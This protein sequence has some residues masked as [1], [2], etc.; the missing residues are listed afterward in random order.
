[1]ET[2][3]ATAFGRV[4]DVQRGDSDELTM[5]VDSIF[6][7]VQEGQSLDAS[8]IILVLSKSL[9]LNDVSHLGYSETVFCGLYLIFQATF[10][11]CWA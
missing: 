8:S 3:L 5:A 4:I 1:M 2:I 10:H 7:G 11:G 9:N 6:R